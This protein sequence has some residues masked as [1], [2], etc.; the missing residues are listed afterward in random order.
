MQ[1]ISL[2][3]PVYGKTLW[4]EN[5]GW[6]RELEMTR[7][8]FEPQVLEP[9]CLLGRP[10]DPMDDAQKRDMQDYIESVL[11]P[12]AEKLLPRMLSIFKYMKLSSKSLEAIHFGVPNPSKHGLY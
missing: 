10:V 12:S 6:E 7:R 1:K 9:K 3:T 8:W 4:D 2:S 5:C 11:M